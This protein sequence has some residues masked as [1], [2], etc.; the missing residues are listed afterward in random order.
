MFDQVR[1]GAA[2]MTARSRQAAALAR[3]LTA[4]TG[5]SCH[6]EFHSARDLGGAGWRIHW[7]DGPTTNEMR[8]LVATHAMWVAPLLDVE[9]VRCER[10]ESDLGFATS[11]LWWL[12]QDHPGPEGPIDLWLVLHSGIDDVLPGW[13]EDAPDEVRRRAQVLVAHGWTRYTGGPL[14]D[15]LEQHARAGWAA[16]AGWLDAL[17]TAPNLEARR[18]ARGRSS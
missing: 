9:A 10:G 7:T 3:A 12:A 16:V 5:T 18:A 14:A 13:P 17:D 4:E 8:A 2:E 1:E 15:Q 11:L 6:A